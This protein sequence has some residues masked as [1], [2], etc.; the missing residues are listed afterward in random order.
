[1]DIAKKTDLTN[2]KANVDTDILK[3]LPTSTGNLESKV[4]KLDVDILLPV[5][6]DRSKFSDTVKNDVVK[7]DPYNAK[8]KNTEDEKP[9]ITNL[10]TNTIFND[11]INK[12]KNEIFT[13]TNLVTNASLLVKEM[14]LKMKH[15]VLLT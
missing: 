7:K 15:P 9:Y 12:I 3:Y 2:L 10:A 13:I 6:V 8:I 5:P 14:Q 11:N 1:M 4:D